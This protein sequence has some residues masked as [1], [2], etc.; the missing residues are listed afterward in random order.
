MNGIVGKTSISLA[1]FSLAIG[2]FGCKGDEGAKQTSGPQNAVISN[3]GSDTMVNLAQTWAEEYGKVKPDVSVEV[4]GGGSGVGIR[5]LMQGI[6]DIANASRKMKDSEKEQAQKNTGKTPVEWI[7]GY[8][9]MAIYVHKDN[10]VEELTIAQLA[11]IYGEG[12]TID[13][14][15]QLGIQIQGSDEIVRVSRQNSSGTYAFFREHILDNKD[16][17]LES[18]DMSGSK[19]VVELVS[20]TPGAIG[21][22]GMGYKID[23]VKFVKI[24]RTDADEAYLP[25][26]QNVVAGNYSLARPLHMY[27]LGQPMGHVKEYIDWILSSA[28]QQI[29][30]KEGYV[31]VESGK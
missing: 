14:W 6:V 25:T 29:V 1:I 15:S 5:D 12:G 4:G 30:E 23:E 28:G 16:F 26:L 19:D 3:S 8:D 11:Q 18:K 10:P 27:T 7:V 13:K 31:P 9:A 21:Y 2:L 22:S 17:K 24:K 20:R